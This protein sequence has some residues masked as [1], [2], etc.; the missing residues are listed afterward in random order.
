MHKRITVPL[1]LLLAFAAS[2][3]AGDAVDEYIQRGIRERNIPGLSLAAIH[4]GRMIKLAAY[5][6]ASLE[7]GAPATGDTAYELPT[8]QAALTPALRAETA[9]RLQAQTAFEFIGE[10]RCGPSHFVLDPD[11]HRFRRYRVVTGG[12]TV[13]Y[14]FNLTREGKV[15]AFRGIDE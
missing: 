13:S 12:R 15:V 6:R 10:E 4:D 8:A 11:V 3:I 14:A 2:L 5:G 7:L 1:A 9:S